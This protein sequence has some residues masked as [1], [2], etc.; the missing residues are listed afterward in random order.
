MRAESIRGAL[1][2]VAA[3]AIA[4]A[5]LV[6][7]LMSGWF[8]HDEGAFAQAAE[9]V[10]AGQVPHRDFDEIYTGL[11]TYIHALSFKIFGVSLASMRWPLLA[12]TVV[13]AM[14]VQRIAMR[15]VP[16]WGAVAVSALCVLWSVP[17]WS[18]PMPS[19][20]NLFFATFGVLFVLNW[21]E[22]GDKRW[23]AAAGVAAGL[24]FLIKLTGLLMVFG[25]MLA[26]VH[27]TAPAATVGAARSEKQGSGALVIV[28]GL[29]IVLGLLSYP[30]LQAGLREFVRM[31]APLAL[32]AGAVS[33]R[34]RHSTMDWRT[35]LRS[36]AEPT[37]P[38]V[39][40]FVFPIGLW[41]GFLVLT[42]ALSATMLGVFVTPFRRLATASRQPPAFIG[43]LGVVALT[44]LMMPRRTRWAQW[45][46][47]AITVAIA[48]ALLVWS[49][50]IRVAYQAMWLTAWGL[51][52]LLIAGASALL[53]RL[54]GAE[55]V[56][57]DSKRDV[58]VLLACASGALMLTEFP[59][60]APAYTLFHLPIALLGVIALARS[61]PSL[62]SPLL[63]L[64]VVVFGAFGWMRL[65]GTA[66]ITVGWQYE[67]TPAVVPLTLE[68]A[69]LRVGNW[70]A[71]LATDLVTRVTTLAPGRT[72]WAGPDAAEVYFLSGV[73]NRT[74]VLFDF[75]A[76][77]S[78]AS[79]SVARRAIGSGATLVV[80]KHD[81]VFSHNP[82]RAD[83][84]ALRDAYPNASRMNGFTIFWR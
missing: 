52:L 73:P 63:A 83:L 14:A 5:L 18:A 55:P 10:L 37:M 58:L 31:W 44:V 33:L 21:R 76:T 60:A 67:P 49:R 13:W 81:P 11:L 75:L 48:A 56:V 6:P 82:T 19:W 2:T 17:N 68:R 79:W 74:R 41:F 46:T 34:D 30:L 40:G 25:V 54:P 70:D 62:S 78:T 42:G 4:A 16:D 38:F 47:I 20:Y 57:S 36:L 9:R 8:P 61:L 84:D 23:L 80:L 35:R 53:L 32:L 27:L 12:G 7:T 29:V 72:M 45:L 15:F 43:Y 39:V 65:H 77:D 71:G 28:G 64:M 50:N 51:P 22:S 24:S 1:F 69:G 26:F 59:F 66:M 3:G